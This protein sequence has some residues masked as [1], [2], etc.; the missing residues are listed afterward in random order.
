MPNYPFEGGHASDLDLPAGGPEALEVRETADP[1]PG[2]GQA[3]IRVHAAGL[4]FAAAMAGQGLYPDAP[5][6]P[7]VA[8]YEAAGVVNAVSDGTVSPT[9]A[10]ACLPSRISE[11]IK[12][13]CACPRSSCFEI[14]DGM[15]FEEAAAIPVNYLT[16]YHLFAA[17][18]RQCPPRRACAG[19]DGRTAGCVPVASGP[20]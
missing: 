12:M 9:V 7:Y 16:A 20:A 11:G 1:E 14:P 5:K 17:L 10:S 2:P 15:S 18:H 3:R 8:G 4:C 6:R 19:A 13:W